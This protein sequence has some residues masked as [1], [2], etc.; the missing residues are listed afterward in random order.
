[1]IHFRLLLASCLESTTHESGDRSFTWNGFWSVNSRLRIETML[2]MRSENIFSQWSLESFPA[3][4]T[5]RTIFIRINDMLWKPQI[6]RR[7]RNK[8][9]LLSKVEC[10][11]LTARIQHKSSSRAVRCKEKILRHIYFLVM[12]WQWIICRVCS[13]LLF[14]KKETSSIPKQTSLLPFD[15]EPVEPTCDW[16]GITTQGSAKNNA[17]A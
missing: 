1:M 6:G 14:K 4:P 16:R 13:F 17:P 5:T 9:E 8:R 12:I 2:I 7:E 10:K 15:I 11:P 3:F